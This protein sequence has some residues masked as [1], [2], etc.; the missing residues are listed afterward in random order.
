M[1]F[2][3]QMPAWLFGATRPV[4]RFDWLR[5]MTGR[6]PS[7]YRRKA[8]RWS[9]CAAESSPASRYAPIMPNMAPLPDTG[10]AQWAASPTRVTRPDDHDGMWT[11][12]NESK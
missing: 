11:W 1:V 2:R 4:K 10:D 12:L 3:A 8:A 5:A 7:S 9:P 6:W